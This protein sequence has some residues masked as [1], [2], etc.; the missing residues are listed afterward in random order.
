MSKDYYKILGV[1]KNASAEELKKAF[2][3]LAHQYHPDK[4]GGDVAKFKTI[5]EAYQVL[6]DPQKRAQY[7]QFG[8]DFVNQAGGGAGGGS[9]FGGFDF[10][11]ANVNFDFGDLE[12]MFG[13][14]G[15][16]F[17]FGG[18]G[19][20]R[21]Q[22]NRG[23]DVAVDVE[24]TLPEAA[25]GV[26]RVLR[27]NKLSTCDTCGGSGATPGSKINTCAHCKGKGQVTRFQQ[28][29]LGA[30]QSVGV[31]PE[32]RGAG[33]TAEKKCG[34]CDGTGT[35]RRDE[36]FT[37]KIPA[38]IQDGEAIRLRGR[39]EAA[40][41]GGQA[42]DL[43]VRIH[44]ATNK[45]L[46]RKGDDIYSEVVINFVTATLGGEAETETLTGKTKIKIPEGIQ[47]GEL[48]KL[49]GAGAA[50]RQSSGRGDH[51]V[52]VIVKTPK[53][54]SRAARRLLDELRPELE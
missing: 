29:I 8:F 26:E 6:S 16:M 19:R 46:R 7:D 5:N 36:Q 20:G 53:K 25:F 1:A 51:L 52:H 45:N 21:Q 23:G 3:S 28:T 30:I 47:S 41:Y 11:G 50:R 4:V 10:N 40:A 9:P 49:R 54:V 32:C 38:G 15:D 27:L 13:G 34:H 37:I 24:L 17:G 35:R 31:C 39:G 43:Y 14:I 44:V 22:G 48:I 33:K 42:G 12:G 2:H 18:G